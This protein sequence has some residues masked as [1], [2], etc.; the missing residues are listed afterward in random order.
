MP[1]PIFASATGPS[2]APAKAQSALPPPTVRVTLTAELFM[3][4]P[5]PFRLLNDWSAPLRS[6]TPPAANCRVL[7]RRQQVVAHQGL[8]GPDLR[9][10]GAVR[11]Q[12]VVE[13]S[14]ESNVGGGFADH[15][16][17]ALRIQ[18]GVG[19]APTGAPSTYMI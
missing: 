4:R 14:L 13:P 8:H 10:E 16:V 19:K 5:V 9:A 3:T 7:P 6:S 2:I 12:E 1:E 17:A 11:D 15:E 18:S